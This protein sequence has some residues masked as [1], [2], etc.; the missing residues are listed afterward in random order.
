MVT[1]EYPKMMYKYPCNV[2]LQ[3][4]NYGTLAVKDEDEE[5]QAVRDG[6]F[7][8]SPEAHKAAPKPADWK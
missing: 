6:W 1:N 3:D 7:L 4:G 5:A 8:T 2:A